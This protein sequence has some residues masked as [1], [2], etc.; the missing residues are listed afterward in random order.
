MYHIYMNGESVGKAIV[1]KEGLFYKITCACIVPD[2]DFYRIRVDDGK[3]SRD[4]G[5][6]VPNGDEF[7]LTSRVPVKFLT[8]ETLSFTLVP[9]TA[10]TAVPVATGE[11]FDYL[12]KLES[13]RLQNTNGQT[14]IVI[15]SVPDQ[16]DNGQNPEYQNI[17]ELP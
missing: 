6:C 5:I 10:E 12:D 13:A 2:K 14:E 11:T 16:Q 7:V 3:T 8:G 15:D 1:E 9:R 4:L 17:W